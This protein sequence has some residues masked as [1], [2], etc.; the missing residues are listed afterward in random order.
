VSAGIGVLV[1]RKHMTVNTAAMAA[2]A[3][4]PAFRHERRIRR[5]R[6]PEI[7]RNDVKQGRMTDKENTLCLSV[8]TLHLESLFFIEA[9]AL[10]LY[11]C[12]V[13]C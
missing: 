5:S 4:K 9:N 7:F 2:L 8:T 10:C 1:L 13:H 12:N 11:T 6:I 3:A